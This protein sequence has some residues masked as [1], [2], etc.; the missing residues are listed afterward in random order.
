MSLSF[1]LIPCSKS[2]SVRLYLD[3]FWMTLHKSCNWRVPDRNLHLHLAQDEKGWRLKQSYRY[4]VLYTIVGWGA[5]KSFLRAEV[6]LSVR[7][8]LSHVSCMAGFYKN[9]IYFTWEHKLT[10]YCTW[11]LYLWTQRGCCWLWLDFVPC[12]IYAAFSHSIMY[13]YTS[14]ESW[15]YMLLLLKSTCV[16]EMLGFTISPILSLQTI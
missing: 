4:Q 8:I 14:S 11:H 13:M 2:S 6:Q 7:G 1:C 16:R 5:L 10:E 9:L 3:T 15:K 12:I